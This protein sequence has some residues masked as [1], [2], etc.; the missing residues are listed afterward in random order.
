[1]NLQ[2]NS[3]AGTDHPFF[4]PLDEDQE[5]WA[6]VE[7]NYKAISEGADEPSGKGVLGGNAVDILNLRV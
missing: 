1:M 7:T 6:S 5:K 2:I 3:E 4:P